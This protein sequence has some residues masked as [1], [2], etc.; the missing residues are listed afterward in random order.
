MGIAEGLE[1]LEAGKERNTMLA[2]RPEIRNNPHAVFLVETDV[3]ADKDETK[4]FT[5]AAPQLHDWGKRIGEMIFVKG[6]RRGGSTLIKPNFTWV[7][8]QDYNR[9]TG[10][11]SSPDFIAGMYEHMMDLGNTNVLAGEGPT[12]ADVHRGGGVYEA[13]DPWVSR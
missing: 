1:I 2:I 6:D 4:H 8:K 11:Y 10:V 5:E 13:F 3:V 9:T 12:A 7:G